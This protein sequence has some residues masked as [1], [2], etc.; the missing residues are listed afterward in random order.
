MGKRKIYGWPSELASI[1]MGIGPQL[2][3]YM[4]DWPKYFHQVDD[5]LYLVSKR[6]VYEVVVEEIGDEMRG[7]DEIK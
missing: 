7:W 2:G 6:G 3:D 1:G 4:P 5:R